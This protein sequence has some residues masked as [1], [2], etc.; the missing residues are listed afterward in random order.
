ML[1]LAARVLPWRIKPPC[2]M[3]HAPVT[4]TTLLFFPLS[5]GIPSSRFCPYADNLQRRAHFI[6]PSLWFVAL[7]R[8]LW[9]LK[10][11]MVARLDPALQ[12]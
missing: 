1:W 3:V 6:M 5:T 7:Q 8:C 12:F 10:L 2:L 4:C 9:H 11:H